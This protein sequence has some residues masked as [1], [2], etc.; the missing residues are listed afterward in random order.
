MEWGSFLY[1]QR[2]DTINLIFSYS[3]Y[4]LVFIYIIDKMNLI[5]GNYSL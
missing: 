1:F 3:K 5:E 4:R 2:I